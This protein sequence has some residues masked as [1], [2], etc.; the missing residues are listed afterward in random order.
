MIMVI[1]NKNM[2]D[3]HTRYSE[4]LSTKVSDVFFFIR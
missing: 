4:E 2:D 3:I 1:N